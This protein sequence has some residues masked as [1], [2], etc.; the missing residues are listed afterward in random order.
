MGPMTGR[1][2]GSC[3]RVRGRGGYCSGCRFFGRRG[4][5]VS[6]EEEEKIL[7]QQLKAVREEREKA[8]QQ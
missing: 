8:K 4:F 7:E 2:M 6:L 5:T 1:G 3:G